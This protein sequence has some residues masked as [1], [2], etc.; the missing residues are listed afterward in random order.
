MGHSTVWRCDR[1]GAQSAPSAGSEMPE[2]WS[3]LDRAAN[4]PSEDPFVADL[5]PTCNTA[6]DRWLTDVD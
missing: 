4:D 2:G 5:C 6:L 3:E 1:C